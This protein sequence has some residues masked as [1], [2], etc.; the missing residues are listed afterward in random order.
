MR[1]LGFT[2]LAVVG[3]LT[4]NLA[5]AIEYEGMNQHRFVDSQSFMSTYE[6]EFTRALGPFTA[7]ID[8]HNA[9]PGSDTGYIATHQSDIGAQAIHFTGST[10][11]GG[12]DRAGG[13]WFPFIATSAISVEFL[14]TAT[15][16]F[17]ASVQA[18]DLGD[19][20]VIS[21]LVSLPDETPVFSG[22]GHF[23]GSLEP[24]R[25]RLDVR[26][27]STG[28]LAFDPASGAE[29]YFASRGSID[30]WLV[31]P[32]PGVSTIGI[33]ALAAMFPRRRR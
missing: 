29:Q 12:G 21:R 26:L 14:N 3:A 25:Y 15:S 5:G 30:A 27:T 24:G 1:S 32:A 18:V 7:D 22:L 20:D 6:Y 11:A 4:S 8:R 17:D 13:H 9:S 33:A 19:T 23:A 31:V 10:W 16:G 2:C 28:I